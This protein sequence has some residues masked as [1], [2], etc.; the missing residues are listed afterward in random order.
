MV[1]LPKMAIIL[2]KPNIIPSKDIIW[3]SLMSIYQVGWPMTISV[4]VIMV[5][6]MVVIVV[7]LHGQYH[8]N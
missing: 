7:N 6:F 2:P 5:V 4:G 8:R 3:P 1:V